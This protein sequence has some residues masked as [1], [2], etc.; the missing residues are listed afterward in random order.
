MKVILTNTPINLEFVSDSRAVVQISLEPNKKY[1]MS[2]GVV[3]HTL[4]LFGGNCL[5]VINDFK[6]LPNKYN[7]H[8]LTNKKLLIIREGG[9]GDLLFNTPVMKYLKEKYP[10]CQIGL[11]CMPVYHTL[12]KS[13]KYID[14]IFPHIFP[15]TEFVKYDYFITFEGIIESNPEASMVN[16]YDLFIKRYGIPETE[17]PVKIPN[18]VVDSRV[19]EFWKMTL[20]GSFTDKN[21]GYQLRASSPVRTLPPELS[22]DII[23]KLTLKGFK[24]FLLESADRKNDLARF[25]NYFQLTGIVDTSVYSTAFEQLA[26]IISLMDLF[27]GPDSS[28]THIAAALGKPIVGLYGPF[29]SDLRLKYYKN[30]VG[31]DAMAQRC[32]QGRGCYQHEYKLCDFADELGSQHAPC[33]N[34]MQSD[35]VV[36]RV[37]KLFIKSKLRSFNKEVS[38]VGC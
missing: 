5:Q 28:G 7:N 34:L 22:A 12:F 31:I 26:G 29:R 24:V 25:V 11:A 21:I 16:A 20:N 2:D 30:A 13:H 9:A 37:E 38:N 4:S 19:Q 14:R 17:I 6:D 8:D 3:Q 15:L 35:V 32:N 27:V 1:I 36:D 23:R 10:S 18:L 33:W